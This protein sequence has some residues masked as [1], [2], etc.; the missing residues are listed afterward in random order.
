ME[1]VPADDIDILC[2]PAVIS[3]ITSET[4]DNPEVVL[5]VN[6]NDGLVDVP[7]GICKSPVKVPPVNGKLPDAVPV[8]SPLKV[9]AA[10]VPPFVIL[11]E[12]KSI[13]PPI[14]KPVKVP[15]EVIFGCAA[16][17]NVPAK[18]VAVI[19]PAVKLPEPSRDTIALAVF[20]LVAFVATFTVLVLFVI[21]IPL[22]PLI[23]LNSKL[24]A[25]F[26]LNISPVAPPT[27]DA[28]TVP[29]AENIVNATS[30]VAVPS[31]LIVSPAP[32]V[33]THVE[34]A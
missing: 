34:F 14:V 24:F 22:L 21:T 18:F 28:V 15:T 30:P 1:T 33:K 25:V 27:L 4:T 8:K 26:C 16:V 20:A 12:F 13:S 6:R 31:G 5:P 19:V 10:I 2:T 23:V 3:D 29:G 7:A 17:V 9:V 11:F 32:S